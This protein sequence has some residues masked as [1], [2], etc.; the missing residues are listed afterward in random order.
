MKTL[1]LR[2]IYSLHMAL[3][4]SVVSLHVARLDEATAQRLRSLFS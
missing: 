2:I 1:W 4:L 3:P